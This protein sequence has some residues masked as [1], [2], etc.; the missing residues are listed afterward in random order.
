MREFDKVTV[1][2]YLI[3]F[4]LLTIIPVCRCLRD[5]C[6]LLRNFRTVG[7]FLRA[8]VND[9]GAGV[10]LRNFGTVVRLLSTMVGMLRRQNRGAARGT[11]TSET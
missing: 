2:L 3:S 4:V 9:R 11:G 8:L 10:V 6:L 1:F 5:C 7:G